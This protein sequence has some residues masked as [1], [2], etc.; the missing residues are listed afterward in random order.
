[1]LTPGV[2]SILA[3]LSPDGRI[4]DESQSQSGLNWVH[5]L[6]AWPGCSPWLH[7]GKARNHVGQQEKS[8]AVPAATIIIAREAEAGLEVF[9]VKRHHQIDFVAGALVFPGGKVAP[10]DFDAALARFHGWRGRL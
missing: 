2:V 10:G 4:D 9:M 8:H 6:A 3:S 5:V 1:M 7:L